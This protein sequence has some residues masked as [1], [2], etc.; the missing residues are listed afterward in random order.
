M[1]SF[2]PYW[3][4]HLNFG[5]LRARYGREDTNV[6]FTEEVRKDFLNSVVDSPIYQHLNNYTQQ[7]GWRSRD[8]HDDIFTS[9]IS[10]EMPSLISFIAKTAY[11]ITN[12]LRADP[13]YRT[14]YKSSKVKFIHEWVRLNGGTNKIKAYDQSPE[15]QN[16]GLPP[17]PAATNDASNPRQLSVTYYKRV[18]YCKECVMP[19][20]AQYI[21]NI[22]IA[23]FFT[24]SSLSVPP[25]RLLTN[26]YLRYT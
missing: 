15:R 24:N 4:S 26:T 8:G 17:Y 6:F 19:R 14:M 12:K 3:I 25:A 9:I 5:E 21:T 20:R 7:T 11:D 22:L 16:Q 23:R 13:S 10:R 2:K 18:D 1:N